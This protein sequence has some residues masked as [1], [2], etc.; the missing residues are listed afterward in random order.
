MHIKPKISYEKLTS[1]LRLN[2]FNL[3]RHL[4]KHALFIRVIQ[5]LEARSSADSS[6]AVASLKM[7]KRGV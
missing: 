2:L 5:N 6:A 1:P 7:V 4:L 3:C